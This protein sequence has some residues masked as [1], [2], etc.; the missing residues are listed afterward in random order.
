MIPKILHR[1]GFTP[2]HWAAL[3]GDLALVQ[4]SSV[5]FLRVYDLNG[6]LKLTLMLMFVIDPMLKTSYTAFLL[7][8]S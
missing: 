4:V 7:K 1:L 2:L 8:C 5:C 6:L 3:K